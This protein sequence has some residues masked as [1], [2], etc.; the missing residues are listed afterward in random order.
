MS[1]IYHIWM[2]VVFVVGYILITIEH[3][4]KINKTA[5]AIVMAVICW[6]LQFFNLG[7]HSEQDLGGFSD[8]MFG[9]S[10]VVFFL[11][12]ALAIVETIS[13]HR[14]FNLISRYI[15]ILSKRKLLWL[16]GFIT[17]F[18]S[19]VLDNLT[20]TII[21][22]TLVRKLVPS[23]EDRLLMGGAV[24]IAANAGGAWTPIGDVTTTMLWI[25][26]QL[27]TFVIMKEL[28]VPSLL[29][30]V[31]SLSFISIFLKGE[32]PANPT[33]QSEKDEQIEPHGK[34]IFWLGISLL[35]CVP[36]FKIVTGLP[37]FM[38]MLLALA[39]M[40]LFTDILHERYPEQQH[41]RLP[42]TMSKVDIASILFFLGILLSITA[43]E[44]AGIL[45]SLATWVNDHVVNAH[46]IAIVLGLVSAIVDNVPLVAAIMGMYN[47]ADYP[48]DSSF[49][50]LVA[51]CAGTGGSILVIGSAAG[52]AFMGMEKVPFFWYL[53]RIGIPALVGYFIGIGY[54]LLTL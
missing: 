47:L 4:V 54:Y 30:L 37:P 13:A 52:V 41:L 31:G 1:N 48:M 40:W 2:T 5:V 11:L 17:F 21:M 8:H 23:G 19:S 3:K 44:S 34:L 7:T 51:Y 36:I 25:G 27:S 26:K 24:V 15:H 32:F 20:A 6:T 50:L 29:C 43:L 33:D 9:I 39:I 28:F 12:G 22:V 45:L 35:I 10:Q 16:I 42:F 49:W 46:L 14:G 38:G 18:F 53:K